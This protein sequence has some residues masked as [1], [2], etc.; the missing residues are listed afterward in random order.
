[1]KTIG[2]IC[3]YNPFHN[4]H[5]RQI[6]ILKEKYPDS[7]VVAIMSGCFVQRGEP[8]IFDKYTRAEA[9]LRGGADLCVGIPFVFS[10][11]SAE[12][13]A[14]AGVIIAKKLRLD[15]ISFGTE[16]DEEKELDRLS[17]FLLSD[18][19]AKKLSEKCDAFPELS[20]MKAGEL[21]VSETLGQRYADII[22]KPNN[23]L[24]LEYIKAIKRDSISLRTIPVLREGEG[25]KSLNASPLPSATFVRE[26]ILCGESLT[27]FVPTRALDVYE[28]DIKEGCIFDY[29]AFSKFTLSFLSLLPKDKIERCIGSVELS[30][31]LRNA[32]LTATDIDELICACIT[33]RYTK[34]RI[35]R[36]IISSLFD[37]VH[38]EFIHKDPEFVQVLSANKKGCE[39][40]SALRKN[41]FPI[42][43]KNADYLNLSESAEFKRQFEFEIKAS[44]IWGQFQKKSVSFNSF[45]KKSPIIES[46]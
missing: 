26:Q 46:R 34:A 4:G 23:I 7:V 19:F 40:L 13:F 32:L 18:D 41:T 44:G 33:A 35:K 31:R 45:M 20:L 5:K 2:I 8:A 3:E 27:G 36:G 24:A 38:N 17:D 16:C 28:R 1:M 11:L 15:A 42:I 6:D 30:N 21:V 43:T 10:S 37:I 12:G 39:V 29:D 14:R 9:S 25:Y 22:S